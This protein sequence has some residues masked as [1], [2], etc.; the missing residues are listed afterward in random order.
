[1]FMTRMASKLTV[2]FA[3]I[4]YSLPPVARAQAIV[5]VI[6]GEGSRIPIAVLS[7]YGDIE[8]REEFRIS[9]IIAADLMRSSAFKVVE[10]SGLGAGLN[11]EVDHDYFASTGT[12]MVVLGRVNTRENYREAHFALVDVARKTRILEHTI[13]VADTSLRLLAH[14]VADKVH[15]QLTGVPGAYAT[16]I[17]YVARQ[18]H[19]SEIL[20]ADADGY[21]RQ[22]VY[23]TDAPIMSP[24]WS[25]DGTRLA[26]VSFERQR[27]RIY[28]HEIATGERR[29]VSKFRGTNSSPAWSPDGS[30]LA[31]TLSK[32]GGS[33]IYLI[34]AKGGNPRRISDSR[35]RDTEPTFSPDG[36]HILFTSDRGGN[37]QI[38]RVPIDGSTKPERVT[39]DGRYNTSPRYAADG[40]WFA[41]VRKEG[42]RFGIAIQNVADGEVRYLT[43]GQDDRS[44]TFAPNGKA[45]LYSTEV[46]GRGALGAISI[47][48]IKRWGIAT[49]AHD[50]RGVAWGPYESYQVEVNQ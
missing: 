31:V 42:R 14:Q 1:M 49:Y 45:I 7:F 36:R 46:K 2:L 13:T 10:S 26:Y 39:F 21:N 43:F 47:D 20:I 18:G 9:E 29:V 3:L 38:Y 23:K 12:A 27:P 34:D 40:E 4:L 50:I 32:D 30:K 35:S 24:Q 5:E 15:E 41:Y 37:P 28:V 6:G 8:E 22:I 16:K 25:P 33:Q 19:G 17:C 11:D 44:P 48:G